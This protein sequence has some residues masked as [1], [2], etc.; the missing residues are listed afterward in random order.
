MRRRC[1]SWPEFRA[2]LRFCLVSVP[3]QF[4]RLSEP[5]VAHVMLSAGS[6]G[7]CRSSRNLRDLLFCCCVFCYRVAFA[8]YCLYAW[9]RISG[10]SAAVLFLLCCLCCM[11]YCLCAYLSCHLVL[12]HCSSLLALFTR[13]FVRSASHGAGFGLELACMQRMM[14]ARSQMC[15][16]G[17]PICHQQLV[18]ALL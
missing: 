6:C 7:G 9:P 10:G 12:L 14:L 8:A 18:L 4:G 2:V 16:A 1:S 11:E 13:Y 17:P 15:L 5:F 3:H